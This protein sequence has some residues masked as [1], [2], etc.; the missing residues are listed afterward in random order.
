MTKPIP[1]GYHSLTPYLICKDAAKA[2]EFYKK[3]LG[4]KEKFRMEGPGGKI[5]HAEMQIGD[6]VIMMADEHLEMNAKS[7]KAYGGSPVSFMLYVEDVDFVSKQAVSAGMKTLR[8]IENQFYGDRNGT[9]EDPFGHVWTIGTHIEDM[10][11]EEATKRA[12]AKYGS[13]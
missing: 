3:A 9:F 4:A 12:E 2:L 6:S 7:P 5:G 1:E 8:P 13:K 10:T 11:P